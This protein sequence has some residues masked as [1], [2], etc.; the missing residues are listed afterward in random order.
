MSLDAKVNGRIVA[1]KIAPIGSGSGRESPISP[2]VM[3]FQHSIER[4][5]EPVGG[6]IRRAPTVS[7][8]G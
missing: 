5:V 7:I 2:L 3:K 4:V 1:V 8:R 6:D